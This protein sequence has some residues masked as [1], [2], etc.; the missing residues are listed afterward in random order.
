MM[1]YALFSFNVPLVWL[2]IITVSVLAMSAYGLVALAERL[3]IRW[4]TGG[5]GQGRAI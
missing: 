1:V 5:L 4:E 2:T 3:V